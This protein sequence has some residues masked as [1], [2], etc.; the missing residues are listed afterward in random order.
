MR[1]YLTDWMESHRYFVERVGGDLIRRKGLT[2]E[3]YMYNVVQ[4]GVPLDKIGILLYA[5]LYKIHFAIILE[6]KYWTTCRDEALNHANIYFIYCGHMQFFYTTRKGSWHSSMFDKL[7]GGTYQ[8]HSHGPI[9]NPFKKAPSTT[10]T[11]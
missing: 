9:E 1:K 7:P 3:D 8:L 11:I 2:V 5:C 4:P 10:R 6:G